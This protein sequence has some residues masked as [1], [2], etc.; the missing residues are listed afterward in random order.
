MRL[1]SSLRRSIILAIDVEPDGR[2]ELDKENGWKG[3]RDAV[4]E[5]TRLRGELETATH[6]A[7]RFNW[8]LRADPQIEGT[9]GSATYVA[10]ACPELIRTIQQ[11]GDASGTHVHTWR[12][13]EKTRVWFNDFD[14]SKWIDHCVDT[15]LAA[16]TQITGEPVVMNRFGDR[17]MSTQAVRALRNNGIKYD[18]TMEPGIPDMPIHDDD[19]STSWL[20]DMRGAPRTPYYPDGDNFMAEAATPGGDLL[21]IP[22]TT[23]RTSWRLVRRSPFIM[24]GSRSPNLVLNHSTVWGMINEA[25]NRPSIA[26]VVIVIR[27][28]DLSNSR[29]R[30]NFIRTTSALIRHPA[31]AFCEFTTVEEAAARWRSAQQ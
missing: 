5:F 27:S 8:F 4:S 3:S 12:W 29:F 30:E 7:V 6:E 26:P 14:D 2:V 13:D 9:W 31:L 28:G 16:V 24:R 21:M 23:S 18:L 15:S 17:W 19:R 1:L 11:S 25:L 20:P 22:V 10:D